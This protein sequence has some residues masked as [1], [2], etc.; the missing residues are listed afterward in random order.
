[1]LGRR[2]EE[3][4]VKKAAWSES[5]KRKLVGVEDMT[6]LQQLTN[7]AIDANLQKRHME[8]EMYTYIGPVLISVNPFRN[9]NIYTKEILFS[10]REKTMIEVPPHVFAVAES[11]LHRMKSY[12]ENQCVII[13]GESGAGKTEAAKKIMLYISELDDSSDKIQYS[14]M[15]M[16]TNPFLENFG[17]AKTLRNNNSSRFGKYIE[18][19]FNKNLQVVGSKISNYLLEKSRVVQQQKNERNFHIFYQLCLKKGLKSQDFY[20]LSQAGCHVADGIND[21]E[22]LKQVEQAM[23]VIGLDKNPVFQILTAILYLGN[24]N[25]EGEEESQI[26]TTE[27]LRK[28][29]ELLLIPQDLLQKALTTAS[30]LTPS[31]ERIYKH[32]NVVQAATV[33]DAM[34]KTIYERLFDWIISSINKAMVPVDEVFKKIGILDIYGFEIFANNGFEQLCINF[35]NEKLQQIFIEL[36]LKSEQEDYVKQEIQWTPI[37]YFDNKVVCELIEAKRPPGIFSIMNDVCT[38]VHA[39]T[40]NADK[41]LGSQLTSLNNKRFVGQEKKFTVRHYAGDVLYTIQGICEKNLDRVNNDLIEAFTESKLKIM[42]ILFPEKVDWDY[43]KQKFASQKICDSAS[44][45]MKT[46]MECNPHYIRCIKPNETKSPKEYSNTLCQHQIEYLGLL[47]NILVRRAGFA[48]RTEATLFLERYYLISPKTCKN[49]ECTWK[50][51]AK[52]GCKEILQDTIQSNQWQLGKTKVFIKSPETLN[53]LE[54]LVDRYWSSKAIK[55]QRAVR[56]RIQFRANCACK[57]QNLVRDFLGTNVQIKMREYA[58][59]ILRDQKERRKLSLSSMRRFYGDYLHVALKENAFYRDT[60]QIEKEELILFSCRV[61]KPTFSFL[62]GTKLSPRV[63]ILTDKFLCVLVTK[64]K[65]KEPVDLID[66]KVGI[67]DIS[68]IYLSPYGD[69]FVLLNLKNMDDLFL[70]VP[71]K[72]ELAAYLAYYTIKVSV[73]PELQILGEKQKK[74]RTITF[75]QGPVEQIK[76]TRVT[77]PYGEPP[78]SR[79]KPKTRISAAKVVKVNVKKT[80]ISTPQTPAFVNNVPMRSPPKIPFNSNYITLYEIK[81]QGDGEISVP[82][83][84]KVYVEKI[85]DSGWTHAKRSSGEAG[86]VPTTYIKPL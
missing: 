49:G 61:Q 58:H 28:T 6:L 19:Y 10:Y 36:T 33:R 75:T 55:I 57:I 85:G 74:I 48:S 76:G 47:Q 40:S 59:E 8:G 52:E 64:I 14:K 44:D 72:S 11:A 23:D 63:L 2:Q 67:R 4:K 77:A 37:E 78:T 66:A 71:F 30:I 60:A 69:N 62:R 56:K 68:T 65:N 27:A 39:D 32:L 43:K 41:Q 13:S 20:Y 51:S 22:E 1:M 45:L 25:F 42:Q 7:Q 17:N 35:V 83:N 9:L 16:A 70:R 29:S 80:P 86:W 73:V 24:I 26:S 3:V 18:L 31:K 12:S 15:I 5:K 82:A 54:E 79:T 53:L 21:E 38:R 84:E 50:K 34:A 46:L 81:A